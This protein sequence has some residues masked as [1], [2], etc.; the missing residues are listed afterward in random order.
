MSFGFKYGAPPANYYFDVAFLKNPARESRWD[1]FAPVSKAMRDFVLGQPACRRFLDSVMPLIRTLLECD[2][3]LR[4][5][6]GCNAGR[7]RSAIVVEEVARRLEDDDVAIKV[8]HR[9]EAYQ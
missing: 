1:L 2:G 6:F 4:V 9:E 5:A 8:V 3:D 7:H